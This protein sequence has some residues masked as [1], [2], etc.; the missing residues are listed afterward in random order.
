L[1]C[2]KIR[3]FKIKKDV[4]AIIFTA[5]IGVIFQKRRKKTR[6]ESKENGKFYLGLFEI[7]EKIV[8]MFTLDILNYHQILL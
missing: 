6:N 8:F 3:K 7:F 4:T 5:V 1:I 2:N